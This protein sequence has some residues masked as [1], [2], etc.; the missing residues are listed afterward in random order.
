MKGEGVNVII[1]YLSTVGSSK[2]GCKIVGI[3]P[4]GLGGDGYLKY[5]DWRFSHD[6]SFLLI[7]R[8]T[9]FSGINPAFIQ[10]MEDAKKRLKDKPRAAEYQ[11]EEDALQII[12]TRH[13]IKYRSLKE[14]NLAEFLRRYSVDT[15]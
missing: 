4:G 6:G 11:L 9:Q 13:N 14:I 15:R 10:T 2:G 5:S 3:Y 1:N 12:K 7:P 8:I